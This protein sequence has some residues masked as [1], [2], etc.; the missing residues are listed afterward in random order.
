SR[1]VPV[2]LGILQACEVRIEQKGYGT[3]EPWFFDYLTCI[4]HCVS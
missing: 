3:C 4:E 1:H 2:A